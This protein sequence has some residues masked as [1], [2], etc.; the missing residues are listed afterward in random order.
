[1]TLITQSEL[2]RRLD[3]RKSYINKLCKTGKLP[4]EG[5]RIR[6]DSPIVQEMIRKKN[7]PELDE[8]E[9]KRKN[10]KQDMELKKLEQQGLNLDIKN[11][12]LRG[13]LRDAKLQDE[14]FFSLLQ[15][16]V[17]RMRG[18]TSVLDQII[19]AAISEGFDSRAESEALIYETLDDAAQDI[20]EQWTELIDSWK[21]TAVVMSGA[22]KIENG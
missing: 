16:S 8:E 11:R 7:Q 21:S 17:D 13:K 12:Q 6:S 15:I 2:A 18:V 22:E 19:A 20:R 4:V 5:T 10:Q 14:A 9:L 1:M 3:C